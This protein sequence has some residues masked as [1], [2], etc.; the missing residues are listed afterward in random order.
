MTVTQFELKDSTASFPLMSLYPFCK[1]GDLNKAVELVYEE[2]LKRW[3]PLTCTT[4]MCSMP[5]L[6]MNKCRAKEVGEQSYS[7]KQR[8]WEQSLSWV[9]FTIFSAVLNRCGISW[10][11]TDLR[12]LVLGRKCHLWKESG[13]VN[14]CRWQTVQGTLSIRVMIIH[15]FY[16]ERKR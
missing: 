1:K 9:A 14:Y 7:S 11:C 13:M 3:K 2:N 5:S 8:T 16:C 15:N 4:G 12:K 10:D 6:A